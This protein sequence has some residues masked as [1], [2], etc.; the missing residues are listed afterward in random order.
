V[1]GT[2]NS[3]KR[4]VT[5]YTSLRPRIERIFA[6][7]DIGAAYQRA[8][9]TSWRQFGFDI[10]SFNSRSEIDALSGCNYDVTFQE[11]DL[12]RPRIVHFFRHFQNS[13]KAVA[14]IVNADCLLLGNEMIISTILKAA[15]SGLVMLE[16]MN[17]RAEDA[18]VT[19]T[20]CYGF[21]FFCFGSELLRHQEFDEEI[22]IGTPWWDYWL[23]LAYQQAGGTLFSPIAPLLIHIDHLQNWSKENWYIQAKRMHAALALHSQEAV[24]FPFVKYGYSEELS[25]TEIDSLAAEAFHWLK[26]SA[27]PI[28]VDDPFASLLLSFLAGIDQAPRMLRERADKMRAIEDSFGWKVICALRAIAKGVRFSRAEGES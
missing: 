25:D 24:A 1:L 9:I 8:C 10:I 27:H 20:S 28:K 4:D 3:P 19:G 2:A 17:V 6:G 5:L 23:P 16:R 21:D 26:K 11:I 18:H 12:D 22:L 14:G 15:K 13:R 7:R